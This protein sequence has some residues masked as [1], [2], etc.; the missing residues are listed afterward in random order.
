MTRITSLLLSLVLVLTICAK[1]QAAPPAKPSAPA[2]PRPAAFTD[3]AEAGPDF[4]VQGEYVGTA[5]WKDGKEKKYGGQI[6]ALGDGKFHGVA[7]FG[8]LPGDGWDKKT[9][10]EADSEKKD[11]GVIFFPRKDGSATWKD[12]VVTIQNLLR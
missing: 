11:G 4:A 8:G 12:G 2:K 7:F 5:P 9:K 10:L 3:P 6:I 1:L